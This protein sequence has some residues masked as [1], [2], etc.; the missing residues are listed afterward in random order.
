[1]PCEICLRT[2]T[3]FNHRLVSMSPFSSILTSASL[4]AEHTCAEEA[5]WLANNLTTSLSYRVVLASTMTQ[6]S[7]VYSISQGRADNTAPEVT[8][9]LPE[10]DWHI[11]LVLSMCGALDERPRGLH[12]N[13]E[14]ARSRP[15]E[16][17]RSTAQF[18]TTTAVFARGVL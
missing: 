1:M 10:R 15:G 11:F 17:F 18:G 4:F 14:G 2:R 12:K 9:R 8:V 16:V 3:P 6:K 13:D 5:N 7:T